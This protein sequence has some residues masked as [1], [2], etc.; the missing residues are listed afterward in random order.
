MPQMHQ[1]FQDRGS[2]G[3]GSLSGFVI[4][5]GVFYLDPQ[6]L[7]REHRPPPPPGPP[8]SQL[9]TTGSVEPGRPKND[10]IKPP[11]YVLVMRLRL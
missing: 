3:S 7:D 1:S 2:N 11:P 9:L 5:N 4:K 10:N 8:R 6:H